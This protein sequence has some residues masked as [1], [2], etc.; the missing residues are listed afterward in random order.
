MTRLYTRRECMEFVA[1]IAC[2]VAYLI[3]AAFVAL[4]I[5]EWV[6]GA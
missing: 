3:A 2:P 5:A 4:E 6:T 1:R